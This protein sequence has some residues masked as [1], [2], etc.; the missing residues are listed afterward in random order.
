MVRNLLFLLFLSAPLSPQE[1]H[2]KLKPSC[3]NAYHTLAKAQ[4]P[5]SPEELAAGAEETFEFLHREWMPFLKTPIPFSKA[6]L[7]QIWRRH[8]LFRD[9][10]FYAIIAK[11]GKATEKLLLQWYPQISSKLGQIKKAVPERIMP[12]LLDPGV[13]SRI[14]AFLDF[15]P[16]YLNKHPKASLIE[17]R[18]AFSEKLGTKTVYRGVSL[19]PQEA[20]EVKRAGLTPNALTFRPYQ[21]EV[22]F[23]KTAPPM[24][25]YAAWDRLSEEMR[26]W[27]QFLWKGPRTDMF[28]RITEGTKD[29]FSQSV[30]EFPEV[31]VQ[32]TREYAKNEKDKIALLKIE[33]PTI[34]ITEA[35][36]VTDK[37][38]HEP[39]QAEG[40]TFY[41]DQPGVE[42]F[43]LGRIEPQWISSVKLLDQ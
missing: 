31:A 30:T 29:K 35:K 17:V 11:D 16:G 27:A 42:H 7:A 9:P 22:Y 36:F 1:A 5:H 32:V 3:A 41:M 2:G 34:E 20:R 4:A 39:F 15:A 26:S 6:A 19:S 14:P 43:V 40:K 10:D 25:S 33:I 28:A 37:M 23:T 18:A 13:A 12:L 8:D 24:N 21:A 38:G